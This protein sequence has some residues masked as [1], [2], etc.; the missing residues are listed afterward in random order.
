MDKN[1][2]SII[3]NILYD[4][5]SSGEKNITIN[6]LS[7]IINLK[8]NKQMVSTI[9][10]IIENETA[11]NSSLEV[12]SQKINDVISNTKFADSNQSI[13]HCS[14]DVAEN[15]TLAYKRSIGEDINN[16]KIITGLKGLDDIIDSIASTDMVVIAARSGHGKSSLALSIA[17]NVVNENNGVIFITLEMSRKQLIDRAISVDTMIPHRQIKTGLLNQEEINC[18]AK[19][20]VKLKS[21]PLYIS[22]GCSLTINNIR[23]QIKKISNRTKISLIII[24]Y[25]QLIKTEKDRE[26]RQVEV[27][28]I[29]HAIKK[30]SKELAIPVIVLAQL[31]RAVDYRIDK[32]PIVADLR[33]SGDI[34]NDAD[35]IFF[36]YREGKYNLDKPEL[37]DKT[38]IIVAKNRSGQCG[39]TEIGFDENTTKFFNL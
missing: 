31:N 33:E 38:E 15:L 10:E 29:S 17:L 8:N 18:V 21:K 7:Q 26:N 27:S 30:M 24:D 22:D 14:Y 34:E 39:S 2:Q 11:K 25:I 6:D 37:K 1:N 16:G 19:S 23:N 32:R 35:M 3:N 5:V 28:N 4:I 12:I 36:I 13:Q 20:I 9:A